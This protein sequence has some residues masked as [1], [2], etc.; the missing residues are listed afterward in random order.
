MQI[1]NDPQ[2]SVDRSKDRKLEAKGKKSDGSGA[3]K[4]LLFGEQL[5]SSVK[6]V[7]N[8]NLDSLLESVDVAAKAFVD[9]PTEEFFERYRDSVR[10]FMSKAQ[11]Q[12]YQVSR[13]F[14][15]HNR[16]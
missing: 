13:E 16:L 9:Q 14:D 2:R 10:A 6:D 8:G 5:I 11:S 4:S 1:G 7:A 3:A 12:A 15:A